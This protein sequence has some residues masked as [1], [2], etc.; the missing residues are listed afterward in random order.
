MLWKQFKNILIIFIEHIVDILEIYEIFVLFYV[1]LIN[2]PLMLLIIV[3]LNNEY[4]SMI[5]NYKDCLIS[6]NELST[7][8]EHW[9]I[10][11]P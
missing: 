10:L 5:L 11:V 4:F 9:V 2:S 6:F 1:L 3:I 8:E 7:F